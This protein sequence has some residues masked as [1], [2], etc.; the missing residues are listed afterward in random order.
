MTKSWRKRTTPA[1]GDSGTEGPGRVADGAG[2][3]VRTSG[4]AVLVV[5]VATVDQRRRTPSVTIMNEYRHKHCV[6]L[7]PPEGAVRLSGL[8]HCA[9]NQKV[10]NPRLRE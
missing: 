7:T 2:R 3:S 8:E 10:T 4:R 1:A 5:P 9:C 6:S